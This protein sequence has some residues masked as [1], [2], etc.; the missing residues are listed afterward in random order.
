MCP[1]MDYL[2]W[3]V[4]DVITQKTS[5]KRRRTQRSVRHLQNLWLQFCIKKM[6]HV[7]PYNKYLY[8]VMTSTLYYMGISHT[9]LL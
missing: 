5:R 8:Y 4:I 7:E 3:A 2:P 6:S 1:C 9:N